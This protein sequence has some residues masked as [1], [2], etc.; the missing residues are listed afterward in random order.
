M[1]RNEAYIIFYTDSLEGTDA[2]SAGAVVTVGGM[3]GGGEREGEQEGETE[4]EMEMET[5]TES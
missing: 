5:E 1:A 4:M 3:R 2:L